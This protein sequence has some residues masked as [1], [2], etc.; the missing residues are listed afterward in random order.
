MDSGKQNA[1]NLVNNIIP[2]LKDK[3]VSLSKLKS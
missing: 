3:A 2:T 1:E